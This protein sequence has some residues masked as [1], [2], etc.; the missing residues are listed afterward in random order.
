MALNQKWSSQMTPEDKQFYQ[1]LGQRIAQFRKTLELTQVQLAEKL[2]I[3]QQTLA[4]YEGGS[5]RIAVAMLK[6]LANILAISVE[7]LLN[8]PTLTTNKKRGP[9]SKLEQQI[10]QIQQLPRTKQKFVME[11]LETVIQQQA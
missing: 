3:A 7:E 8:D 1:E 4:H 10:E 5:L 9:S 2:G 6:P 11:M